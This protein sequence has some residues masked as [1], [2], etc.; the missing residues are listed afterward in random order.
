MTSA[1]TDSALVDALVPA[2]PSSTAVKVASVKMHVP[3]ILDIAKSS[4]A[5]WCMLVS[6]LLGKYELS[7]HVDVQTPAADRSA[8]WNREDFI[9]RSWLYGYMSEEILNIIMVENQTAYDVYTLMRNI[10]LDN[11]MTR[12]I[13]LEAEFRVFI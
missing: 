1:L 4:Y 3:V 2:A 13:H 10:L 8:E 12:A 9:V 5:K 11:H 7:N 6:V